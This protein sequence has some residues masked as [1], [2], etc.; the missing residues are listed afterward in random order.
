M[1]V[2]TFIAI[3]VTVVWAAGYI[4]AIAVRD[5]HPD[6]LVNGVMMLIAGYFFTTGIKKGNGRK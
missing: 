2:Q 3:V 1:N 6:I 4:A 5:F